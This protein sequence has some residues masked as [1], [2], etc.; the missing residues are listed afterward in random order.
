[1]LLGHGGGKG[2]PGYYDISGDTATLPGW[3]V[4]EADRPPENHLTSN[5]QQQQRESDSP[6]VPLVGA[7]AA[8]SPMDSFSSPQQHL[9]LLM[10]F[11][12][13]RPRRS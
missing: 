13:G 6:S 8:F 5:L 10:N 9:L 12:T 2:R 1:M 11:L 7:T 4:K 3:F